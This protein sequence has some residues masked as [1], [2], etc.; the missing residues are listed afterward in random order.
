MNSD[1]AVA[2]FA[3]LSQPTR[4]A[5]LR[6]L[7]TTG[8]QGLAAGAVAERTG[9]VPS[10]LSH[11]LGLLERARLVRVRREGRFIFYAAD[12]DGARELLAFVNALCCG[13]TAPRGP[14]IPNRGIA[15]R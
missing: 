13:E 2:A 11:H 15:A 1:A 12:P 8:P 6:L 10:T 4:L 14:S 3:A 7:L 9:T 5:V